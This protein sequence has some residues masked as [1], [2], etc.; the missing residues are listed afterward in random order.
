MNKKKLYE[1]IMRNVAK[2]V[3]KA[4][5]ETSRN[6]AEYELPDDEREELVDGLVKA[7]RK[8]ASDIKDEID[9]NPR[10]RN[11][12]DLLREIQY[13]FRYDG[14]ESLMDEYP[15]AYSI[16]DNFY[17]AGNSGL[18]LQNLSDF[19]RDELQDLADEI[20]LELGTIYTFASRK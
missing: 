3:K 2:Q 17:C 16:Y 20:A 9:M 8:S 15:G 5:N 13:I 19:D 6:G 12:F 7:F 1:S 14:D 18:R 11:W 4:L 10:L